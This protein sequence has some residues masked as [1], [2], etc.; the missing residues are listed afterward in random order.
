MTAL[1]VLGHLVELPSALA[2]DRRAQRT[3]D[4]HGSGR[5]ARALLICGALVGGLLIALLAESQFGAW[6]HYHHSRLNAPAAAAAQRSAWR[7]RYTAKKSRSSGSGTG[8]GAVHV[9]QQVGRVQRA[10]ARRR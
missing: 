8:R 1:H 10:P 2:A 3:W 9:R 4:D 6:S 5:G 7:R